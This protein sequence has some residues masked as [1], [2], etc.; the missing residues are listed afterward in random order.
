MA[1]KAMKAAAVMIRNYLLPEDG[2]D[3]QLLLAAIS[4]KIPA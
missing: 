4:L 2:I 1:K 3:R